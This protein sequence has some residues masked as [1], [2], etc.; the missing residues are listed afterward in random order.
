MQGLRVAFGAHDVLPRLDLAVA[1]GEFVVL[2]GP[3]G[4]G[5][6][7]LLNA[8]AGLI[9]IDEGSVFIGGRDVT[10]LEPKERGLA[11]VFQSYALY[12][13]MTVARQYGVCAE[14]GRRRPARD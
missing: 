9:D 10:D 6:S 11:M 8:I 2:L 5:K 4:C 1:D 14:G 3:S 13:H 12:P 7:T